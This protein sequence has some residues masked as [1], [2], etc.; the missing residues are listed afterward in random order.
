VLSLIC[1]S[2][3]ML[4][5]FRITGL[6]ADFEIY[7]TVSEAVPAGDGLKRRSSCQA[8]GIRR[9]GSTRCRLPR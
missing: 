9:T 1:S 4:R 3:R 8:D 5:L 7:A 2:D 6:A